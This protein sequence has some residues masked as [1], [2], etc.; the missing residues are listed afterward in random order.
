MAKDSVSHQPILVRKRI[1]EGKDLWGIIGEKDGKEVRIDIR[2]MLGMML[3][4]YTFIVDINTGDRPA[5][6][7]H[8]DRKSGNSL[9]FYFKTVGD[10][11]R[12]NNFAAVPKISYGTSRR[13]KAYKE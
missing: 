9:I 11:N 1:F 5:Q 2:D 8:V 7:Q 13:I 6:L 10:K 3:N 4:G 12:K